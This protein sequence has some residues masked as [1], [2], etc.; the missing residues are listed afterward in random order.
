MAQNMTIDKVKT[1][2][3]DSKH[4][5]WFFW[6]ML[7]LV[8]DYGRPQDVLPMIGSI[9]PA[10]IITLVLIYYLL[11][12]WN[13]RVF[14]SKQIRLVLCFV[15]LTAIFIPFA[16]NNQAAFDTTKNMLLH[17]PFIL[18]TII[19]VYSI[20]RL[21]EML[22]VCMALMLYISLY[23]LTHQGTGSGNY[24]HDE[25]DLSLYINMWLPFYYFFF[26]HEKQKKRKLFYASGLLIGLVS[27]VASFSRGG[28]VGLVSMAFIILLFSHRKVVFLI[29]ICLLA[30]M[31]YT[32]GDET[33]WAEMSTATETDEGTGRARVESWKSAWRM[34]IDNPLGVGGNNFQ[35]RFPEYQTDYFKR[36]MW[37]IFA[38]S[39]WF[40]L[41]PELGIVGIVLYFCLLYSNLKDIFFLK[42]LQINNNPDLKYLQSLS[43]AFI[44]SFTGFF[45]SASFLSVLYYPH[46]WY[47]TGLIVASAGV[48]KNILVRCV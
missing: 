48:S 31:L 39:L 18:S 37:G 15:I 43:L 32:Y 38:H 9:K 21:K 26:F 3:S 7:F 46:Y 25:N 10:M 8:F 44:V 17:L 24:F 34:F 40:T 23:S 47:L 30:C 36:G 2:N 28:F 12:N 6:T 41:I 22:F 33:Y 14:R 11:T 45:T 42:K 1:T 29:I 4:N 35:V 5:A 13:S 19:C 20:D 16:R 27:V